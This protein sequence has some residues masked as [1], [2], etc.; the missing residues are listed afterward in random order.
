L[1]AFLLG[2]LDKIIKLLKRWTG[3]AQSIQCKEK[4]GTRPP[5]RMLSNRRSA[6]RNSPTSSGIPLVRIYV[7]DKVPLDYVRQLGFLGVYH[8]T[9]GVQPIPEGLFVMSLDITERKRQ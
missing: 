6:S 8:F 9:R 3:Y 7:P 2:N 5:A 4:L 1:I